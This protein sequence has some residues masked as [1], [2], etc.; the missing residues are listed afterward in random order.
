MRTVSYRTAAELLCRGHIGVIPTD[1]VYGLVSSVRAQQA[2]ERVY[3]VKRRSPEKSCIVLINDLS[4]LEPFGASVTDA[5]RQFVE[6]RWPGPVSVL[7]SVSRPGALKALSG[8][9][10]F[11]LPADRELRALVA[12]AGPLIAPSANIENMRPAT[13][14]ADADLYFGSAV[15]FCVDGGARFGNPSSLVV[16]NNGGV[17]V[18]RQS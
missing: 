11:R 1:T 2:I 16:I 10:A 15:D 12:R 9:L 7:L 17:T 13:T 3:A 8:R 18:L 6:D 14:V 4:D 5:E